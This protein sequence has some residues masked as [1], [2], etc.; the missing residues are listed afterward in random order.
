LLQIGRHRKLFL[1]DALANHLSLRVA[2]SFGRSDQ[3]SALRRLH[4]VEGVA[5]HRPSQFRRRQAAFRQGHVD[6]DALKLKQLFA[7]L[8]ATVRDR[9]SQVTPALTRAIRRPDIRRHH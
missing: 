1:Q 4:V 2:D 8:G 6:A 9:N 3:Y 5:R 7:S